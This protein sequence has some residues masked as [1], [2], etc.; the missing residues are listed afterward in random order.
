VVIVPQFVH[1]LPVT[2]ATTAPPANPQGEYTDP[3]TVTLS[4]TAYTG[5]TIQATYYTIDG[6][7]KQTYSAPF[8]VSG[9]GTHSVKYWSVDNL[10]VYESPGTLTIKIV[11]LPPTP[12]EI[13]KTPPTT[14]GSCTP[15]PNANGWNNTDVTVNL[16][17]TDNGSGVKEIHYA[18][19]GGV[20]R[21]VPGASVSFSITSE[22]DSTVTYFAKDY[23][24]NTEAA[25][26]LVIKIDKT[27]PTITGS[28]TPAP[29]AYGWNNGNVTVRFTATDN[30]SGVATVSPDVTI[31]TEGAGQSATGTATDKAGN[32]ASVTISNINI[33]KSKP[34]ISLTGV[35]DG[36]TVYLPAT[37]TPVF[38]AAD[39]LDPAPVVT[40]ILDDLP[41]TSNA[42]IQN[43]DNCIL[44]I[45]AKDQAGNTATKT[46]KFTI[47]SPKMLKTAAIAELLAAKTGDKEVD[48]RMDKAVDHVQ[49]SLEAKLWASDSR[50][51]PQHG[52]KVFDE[53]KDAVKA[54]Q[55]L[56]KEKKTPDGVKPVCNKVIDEL[57]KADKSL[58]EVAFKDAQA[59]AGTSK[60][61][62]H[63]IAKAVEEFA[64][65]QEKMAKGEYDN[66]IDCYKKA[67][68]HAQKA[69]DH[70]SK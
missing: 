34:T 10:G 6:G 26:S 61:V 52:N 13:D 30:P 70:A 58:A 56:L 65:V 5:F 54:M 28:R 11:G 20:E 25:R 24:G 63:E 45:Q 16:T 53:E 39:N 35:A 64:N 7:A 46:V 1:A 9:L 8:A 69:I 49:K 29:N 4:A 48:K 23:A 51:D 14:T 38:S 17:A 2:T 59:Y 50:L 37:V 19:N 55:E 42:T 36:Y 12:V 57:L 27:P 41:F 33:D 31:S 18:L 3:V 66:A 32:A 44:T 68:E 67:W 43:S 22:G 60:E 15:A 62:D 21:I 47:F 40:A